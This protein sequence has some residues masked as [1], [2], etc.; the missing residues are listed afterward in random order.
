VQGAAA[1]PATMIIQE[2]ET[3]ASHC[4]FFSKIGVGAGTRTVRMQWKASNT[5]ADLYNRSM[6][7]I[8]NLH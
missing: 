3:I 8:V 2:Q 4:A 7:V 6:F 1:V 5:F